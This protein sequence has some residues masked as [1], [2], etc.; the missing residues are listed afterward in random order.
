[1]PDSAIPI[2][3][4]G[5]LADNPHYF[6]D[7]LSY[8][9]F[10]VMA[11]QFKEIKQP[12]TSKGQIQMTQKPW[13]SCSATDGGIVICKG[14]I[15][16][17]DPDYG[18]RIARVLPGSEEYAPVIKAAPLGLELALKLVVY[19]SRHIP[20]SAE[21]QG[22]WLDMLYLAWDIVKIAGKS[23]L[24]RPAPK[25]EEPKEKPKEEQIMMEEVDPMEI[26]REI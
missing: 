7:S 21:I 17:S 5:I 11:N 24:I 26:G 4:V 25:I 23:G 15:S 10:E 13:G 18:R 19:H 3:G 20:E 2:P 16:H 8:L 22:E 1:M 14:D 12:E 6:S 9:T